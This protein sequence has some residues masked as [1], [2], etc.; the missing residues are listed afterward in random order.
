VRRPSAAGTDWATLD[1]P[2][3]RVLATA[4]N[5]RKLR[6]GAHS[7]NHFR[8]ALRGVTAIDE[9]LG[10][11]LQRIR[12]S[13]VPNY[14]GEQRFGR[15]AGNIAMARA[16]FSGSRLKREDRSIAL[17]AARSLIFNRILECRVTNGTW[18]V[19]QP[20][21]L[22]NLDG[23]GS[24]FPVEQPDEAIRRRCGELD[25]HPGAALW[26]QGEPGSRG[27]IASLEKSVIAEF[28]DLAT[29]LERHTKQARR[30][31]RLAVR[32]FTWSLQG[33]VLWLEFFLTRGGFA[34]AVLREIAEYGKNGVGPT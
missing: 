19:I 8:I 29:G 1:L 6:R 27:A 7:G 21:E 20:G 24:V 3:V 5:Q 9:K 33:D 10:E 26:G 13:G 31:T 25:I 17:S 22:V 32:D 30:A 14:F 2:G 16:F 18:N 11:L 12:D 15:D 4:R 28:P 23:S 34:T